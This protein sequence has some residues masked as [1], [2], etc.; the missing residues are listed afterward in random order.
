MLSTIKIAQIDR[1]LGPC[2]NWPQFT[3]RFIQLVMCGC[4][5]YAS[6]PHILDLGGIIAYKQTS[7]SSNISHEII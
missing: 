2:V 3:L 7:H 6:P 5:N 1:D 4:G